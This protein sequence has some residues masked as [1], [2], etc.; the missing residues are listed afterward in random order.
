MKRSVVWSVP[1]ARGSAGQRRRLQVEEEDVPL[2]GRI[3]IAA[4]VLGI[5]A[6]AGGLIGEGWKGALWG[7]ILA[8]PLALLGFAAPAALGW[9]M[10]VIQVFSCAS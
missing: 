7:T 2:W 4:A 8:A 5:G 3:L 9:V 1:A 10:A 6:L